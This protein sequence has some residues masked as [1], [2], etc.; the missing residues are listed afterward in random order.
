MN[1]EELVSELV[2][3]NIHLWLEGGKLKFRA[4]KEGLPDN[5]RSKLI[6][7][8]NE[9]ISLLNQQDSGKVEESLRPVG[10]EKPLPLSFEQERLWFLRELYDELALFNMVY[11]FEWRGF[12]DVAT[13]EAAIRQ[14]IERHEILRSRIQVING[15][16]FQVPMDQPHWNLSIED[17]PKADVV[18]QENICQSVYNQERSTV[19]DLA[20][21]EV[22]RTRMLRFDDRAVLVFSMHHIVSDA[23]SQKILFS[24][25]SQFYLASINNSI[26]ELAPLPVQYADYAVWCRQ[27]FAN[28]E[29]QASIDFWRKTLDR[30][31]FQ[32]RLLSDYPRSKN[33]TFHGGFIAYT[34]RPE[35][36]QN[37]R[38]LCQRHAL[39][40]SSAL[41][42]VY[43]LLVARYT[44]A[45]SVS[46]GIPTAG[47]EQPE[48]QQL[49]GFFV[50]VIVCRI[51]IPESGSVAAFMQS[52]QQNLLKAWEHQH[53]PI[54]RVAEIL[55]SVR[56]S[57]EHL[58]IP[59][60]YNF[61]DGDNAD[62]NSREPMNDSLPVAPLSLGSTEVA[63]KH[64]FTLSLSP[65]STGIS[66]GVEY[67]VDLFSRETI[68]Q[69][70]AHFDQLLEHMICGSEG[71][72]RFMTW[73]DDIDVLNWIRAE[74]PQ[75]SRAFPLSPMQR[76]IYFSALLDPS[77]KR[78][79]L[80]CIGHIYRAIDADRW[81]AA[82]T[83]LVA[84]SDLLRLRV[85][86]FK[87]SRIAD[88]Y[89]W[90]STTS[91]VDYCFHDWSQRTDS[92]RES[93]EEFIVAFVHRPF[94]LEN[95]LLL[96]FALVRL[97][98]DHYVAAVAAHH[99]QFD[100]AA[101]FAFGKHL[102][103]MYLN[104]DATVLRQ[105]G[106]EEYEAFVQRTRAT[107][108]TR[109]IID[110]WRE[111]LASVE[112]LPVPKLDIQAGLVTRVHQFDKDQWEA[113]KRYCRHNGITPAIYCKGIYGLLI[114][115]YFQ[116]QADFLI[117]EFSLGRSE[118]QAEDFGCY[119]R[120]QPFVFPHTML[121]GG[122][123]I[124]DFW[125]YHKDFQR[126]CKHFT[127]L[128]SHTQAQLTLTQ[129]VNFLYNFNGY[130]KPVEILYSNKPG[131]QQGL[132]PQ[133]EDAVQFYVKNVDQ[134]MQI[135][136]VYPSGV[137]AD[138]RLLERFA[139]ITRQLCSDNCSTPAVNAE[140]WVA[141]LPLL[142]IEERC[143]LVE[144]W[145]T[146]EAVYPEDKCIHE[147]FEDQVEKTPEAI[148]VIHEEQQISY[149]ELNERANRL[150]R[151][152]RKRGVRADERVA[153]CVERS[154]EMVVGLLAVL[155]AGGGYVP[156][157][158]N[159]PAERLGYMLSDSAPVVVLTDAAGRNALSGHVGDVAVIDM[160]DEALWSEQSTDNP[161]YT[162]IGLTPR[163][164]AYVIYTSGST[165]MPKGVAIE[166][167]GQTNLL[168]WYCDRF[169]FDQY[170]RVLL[171]SSYGFDLTQKNIFAPLITGG[172]LYLAPVG[173][174]PTTIIELIG[175]YA[176]TSIN[177]TPSMFY[178]LTQLSRASAMG[179][180]QHVVLGGEP[181]KGEEMALWLDSETGVQVSIH[182]TYGPTECSD[183]VSV[184]SW[185][186]GQELS[187][188]LG[189][190]ISNAQIYIL[191]GCGSPVPVGVAG[192]LTIGGVGVGRG[193]LSRPELT[194]EKFIPDPF[195]KEPG[196]RLYRTGD[197]ARYRTDGNIEYLGR[198][199][200]QV[201]IRGFRIELGEI[202]ARLSECEGVREA[203]VVA[204]Q[205]SP[206]DKRLVAY[207]T[208]EG[209][210]GAEALRAQLLQ[211]LP[212][213]MVP[214]AY[215]RLEVLPL[216]PNGKLDRKAL[217]AP[218]ADAYATRDYEAPQGEIE[219][220]LA[221][222]WSELL[223]VEQ[224]GRQDN[225]FA[226]GG[227]SLLVGQLASR[228]EH[229]FD[230]V[231]PLRIVFQLAQFDKLA[232]EIGR[233]LDAVVAGA[234]MQDVPEY[235]LKAAT[236]FGEAVPLTLQHHPD[237]LFCIH[238]GTGE[239]L[240]Y[241]PLAA[242]LESRL[243]VWG[244]QVPG[245]EVS[246]NDPIMAQHAPLALE[247]FTSFAQLAG[248]Y[249]KV[250]TRIQPIGPYRLLGSSMGGLFA[251]EIARQLQAQGQSVS[252]VGMVDSHVPDNSQ[253]DNVFD[254]YNYLQDS[255][256]RTLHRHPLYLQLE[257]FGLSKL[258][259][260]AQMNHLIRIMKYLHKLERNYSLVMP[261]GRVYLFVAEEQPTAHGTDELRSSWQSLGGENLCTRVV[262]GNHLT[263]LQ[264]NHAVKFAVELLDILNASNLR[265][266]Q[267]TRPEPASHEPQLPAIRTPFN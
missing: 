161:N 50:S 243:S 85:H 16:P 228:I 59:M 146:T 191:D 154:V 52:V 157:D 178:P 69:F 105:P 128:S 152:L 266:T 54:E 123:T 93:L 98:E 248:H 267:Q 209:E 67:N 115:Y 64:E 238:S 2:E 215:V 159:Y 89:Q 44:S 23:W 181:I 79:N 149:G 75:A 208:G 179:S 87:D 224:V 94:D 240:S 171:I 177:C 107:M 162:V 101:V 12:V 234:I 169:G 263:A 120:P 121:Q 236:M 90:L 233:Q 190:P 204:R 65:S 188:P 29:F 125:N 27:R 250:I 132:I 40:L 71:P 247:N 226:L 175:C 241:F 32:T 214:A 251:L 82:V 104:G 19:F 196:A 17:H 145:N 237:R 6:E 150:A 244:I 199:D 195:A 222:I 35:L 66:G 53:V 200:F 86:R 20:S 183:V 51:E 46:F 133:I 221:A 97:S 129:N 192:E 216:T 165:G 189:R 11:A 80:G 211:N 218:D 55:N 258:F 76:D 225:F 95:D 147:L 14:V 139:R 264:K 58:D 164:L 73:Y 207:T 217:P 135:N 36:Q 160:G 83:R 261:I 57:S 213:Y 176:I 144:E 106:V 232:S 245:Y 137:F 21:G 203:V 100:G 84:S 91:E 108:D 28:G 180:M 18:C 253:F 92:S 168:R 193:Y 131:D 96:R 260:S 220:K 25:L 202:E 167:S 4:P 56:S 113:V 38:R 197:L 81:Q 156:L 182:N 170:S 252:F 142:G 117:T 110:F 130:I 230:L 61:V 256:V 48:L 78:N 231:L 262:S 246:T 74:H 127:G 3:N 102:A 187:F 72:L 173:Y 184:A 62:G 186:C 185:H 163:H 198:N 118:A 257:K 143:L 116:G 47:R 5:I 1:I 223:K 43:A 212:E 158:P 174:E 34:M 229:Q 42:A 153:I 249:C 8:R 114:D 259:S 148:A 136:L 30:T 242:H 60:A 109:E 39:T 255:S 99:V 254:E 112:P 205:D 49:I 219:E 26:C 24:E 126:A 10:R 13:L 138:D 88:V 194:A 166:H 265:S 70:L 33:R 151:Q 68:E 7:R 31:S 37:L 119:Y 111:K 239:V 210:V 172:R 41:L 22:M 201:K 77:T 15:V 124:A 206:G 140:K 122:R 9:I 134:D 45:E 103:E 235:V 227:H 141:D 63:A 155:K